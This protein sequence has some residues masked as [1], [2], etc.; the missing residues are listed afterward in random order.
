M[1]TQLDCIGSKPNLTRWAAALVM[2]RA[3]QDSVRWPK[4]SSVQYKVSS[5]GP[6]NTNLSSRLSLICI[7]KPSILKWIFL[8]CS[9]V[10]MKGSFCHFRSSPLKSTNPYSIGDGCYFFSNDDLIFSICGCSKL[11][12]PFEGGDGKAKSWVQQSVVVNE[13]KATSQGCTLNTKE[14][15]IL[16]KQVGRLISLI[17]KCCLENH[18]TIGD[19]FIVFSF[20]SNMSFELLLYLKPYTLHLII[21]LGKWFK[22]SIKYVVIQSH[23][24][25]YNELFQIM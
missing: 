12:A 11:E 6:P 18:D 19:A 15:S 5:P 9:H 17:N 23:S 1:K 2:S 25:K 10:P 24:P 8:A 22:Y 14:Q 7:C 21:V 20:H 16:N 13:A 4:F 3:S